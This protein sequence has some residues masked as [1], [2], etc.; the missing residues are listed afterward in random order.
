MATSNSVSVKNRILV[1]K[2]VYS[3]AV[4]IFHKYR[5]KGIDIITTLL[6]AVSSPSNVSP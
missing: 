3:N 4:E 5:E 2:A 6:S 1:Y